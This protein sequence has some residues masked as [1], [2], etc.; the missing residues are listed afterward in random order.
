MQDSV[1]V[2]YSAE[3]DNNIL[4][5]PRRLYDFVSVLCGCFFYELIISFN[6]EDVMYRCGSAV[7][8]YGII[9]IQNMNIN[10]YDLL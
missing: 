4:E 9:H 5:F 6:W 8:T 7:V 10:Y 3:V 2:V 1:F